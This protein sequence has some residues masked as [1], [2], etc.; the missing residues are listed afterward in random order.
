MQEVESIWETALGRDLLQH[1]PSGTIPINLVYG[2]EQQRTE[3]ERQLSKVI[4]TLEQQIKAMKKEYSQLSASYEERKNDFDQQLSKYR[5]EVNNYNNTIEEWQTNGPQGEEG[6]IEEMQ[7]RINRLKDTVREKETKMETLRQR[8]NRKSQRL[9][10][11]IDKQNNLIAQYD[12]QF[13][14][15]RKFDQGQYI[16]QG[17]IKRINIYQ[18]SNRAELT[19]VLAHETGHAMGLDHVDNPKSIMNPMMGEQDIFNLSLTEED[20]IAIR[21]QCNQ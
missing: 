7:L 11:L 3:K 15:D 6:I 4:E 9:N 8:T 21:N 20:L 16:K 17:D 12:R 19:A 18:F 5:Q 13:G 10:E 14:E 1:S 2:E